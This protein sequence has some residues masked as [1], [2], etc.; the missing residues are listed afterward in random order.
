M[1]HHLSGEPFF[2]IVC[3]SCRRRVSVALSNFS[4]NVLCLRCEARFL[5]VDPE[6][7]SAAEDDPMR[8]WAEFTDRED[9]RDDSDSPGN[10]LFRI[11]R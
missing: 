6:A 11:P 5:A 1:N 3:P 2:V 4:K 8:Y 7:C 10:D 9:C